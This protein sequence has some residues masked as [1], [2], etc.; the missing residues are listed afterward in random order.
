[1]GKFMDETKQKFIRQNAEDMTI[2]DLAKAFKQPYSS[3]HAY[4]TKYKIKC[5]SQAAAKR[6]ER[7][8]QVFE[9]P[10]VKINGTRV[11]RPPAVYTNRSPYGIASSGNHAI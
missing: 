11:N 7:N 4:C 2:S 3:M 5:K 6:E 9:K 8:C 10:K 1:M